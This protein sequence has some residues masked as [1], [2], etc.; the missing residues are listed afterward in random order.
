[1]I[2]RDRVSASPGSLTIGWCFPQAANRQPIR[3][4]TKRMTRTL[5]TLNP[6]KTAQLLFV[7][8]A[9]I[10]FLLGIFTLIRLSDGSSERAMTMLVIGV[11]MFGNAAAMLISGWGIG[12]G[13]KIFYYLAL[14]VLFVNIVLTF[15][16][17]FG[18][19]DLLT[20]IVD[21]V[22]LGFLLAARKRFV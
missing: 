15:T 1:L 7:L 11:M 9:I 13:Q 20:L 22:L 3:S 14:A 18:L 21:L 10:W 12:R 17:E 6:V 19:L 5:Q 8:N 4:S 16:D 2:E